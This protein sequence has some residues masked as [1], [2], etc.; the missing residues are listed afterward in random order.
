MI[1]AELEG[2]NKCNAPALECIGTWDLIFSDTQL[3]RSSP[4]F[5]AGRAVCADGAEAQRYDWCAHVRVHWFAVCVQHV[6]CAVCA[7]NDAQ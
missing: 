1:A 4:F 3:F 7:C 6:Q 5:M 2:L